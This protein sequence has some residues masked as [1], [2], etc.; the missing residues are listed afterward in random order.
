[1]PAPPEA[2]GMMRHRRRGASASLALAFSCGLLASAA[3]ARAADASV[4]FSIK[5]GGD[6][7]WKASP[8]TADV[9]ELRSGRPG[10][11]GELAKSS[12][13]LGQPLELAP[14]S[15]EAVVACDADE[16]VVKKTVPF[17]VKGADLSVPV[18]LEP[19]FL[20]VSVLRFDTPVRAGITVIDERGREV[21]AS[22]EKAIIPLVPGRVHVLARVN[23]KEG[24]P[25]L[26]NAVA[27]VSARKKT[28][29]TVDTTDGELTV[30]LTDN[31][32][33]AGGVA[34]LRAPGQKTRLVELRAGEK[35]SVP[36][37]TYDLVTQLDDTH[38]F[39]EVVT[40]NVVIAPAKAGQR[41]V[42]HRTGAVKPVILVDGKSPPAGTKLE[43]ELFFPGQPAPFNTVAPG[44]ALRL[45]PGTFELGARRTDAFRD[46]GTSP[47]ARQKIVVAAGQTKSVTLD[48]ASAT[49]DVT[50]LVGGV[51]RG[52]DVEV[53]APGGTTP[54]ARKTAGPDGKA[55]F[56][57]APGRYTA[58]GVLRA[59]QG[60]VVTQQSVSLAMG[61]RI[62]M[63]LNLL[64]GTAVVQVFESG[65]AVPAEVRFYD[66]KQGAKDGKPA[67]APVLVVPGGQEAILPPGTY[68]LFVKRK[69]EERSYSDIKVTAGR[70]VERSVEIAK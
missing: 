53:L 34:A 44:E 6:L 31:G 13:D 11:E 61:S 56:S 60:D 5:K 55:S 35:G 12:A 49:L 52:L 67:G 7:L 38:D 30:H 22:K 32:K 59:P 47:S 37:G 1:M 69:G 41:T 18:L 2:P 4:T 63:K 51:P 66:A 70:T 9:F 20:L 29:V 58:R 40:K 54:V 24:R 64:V 17:S 43:L 68:A 25:V 21:A 36:P 26:G 19:G 23:D 42:A 27:T 10:E 48:L 8:C 50:A 46:D 62:A 45:A 65:V 28:E 15:Y 3:A 33:K 39:G 57:L 14:G 16:G